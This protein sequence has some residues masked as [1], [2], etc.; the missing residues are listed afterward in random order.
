M[1]SL[2]IIVVTYNSQDTVSECLSSLLL[3]KV[4]YGFELFVIDNASTDNTV[5]IIKEKFTDAILICNKIN[6]G[7]GSALNQGIRSS[8]GDYILALNSDVILEDNFINMLNKKIN[9]LSSDTG[10][11]SP[12]VMCMNNKIDSA[13]LFLSTLRRLYDIGRGYGKQEKFN[14][15]VYIFGACGACAVYKR[16][17]LEDIKIG[18]EYFDEDFF[19]FVEDFDLAWRAKLLKW[20]VEYVPELECF[21]HG[22]ISRK[23]TKLSQYYAF[24][25]RYFLLIKNESMPGLIKI[26]LFSICYD[27]PRLIYLLITNS[28]TIKALR[29]I[30]QMSSAMAGKRKEIF[31]KVH[32]RKINENHPRC[33]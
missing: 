19:L 11:V 5:N 29:E 31:G 20:K 33:P 10:I 12:R 2:S 27:F 18:D 1:L 30:K 14:L 28:Y 21:H 4:D 32:N 7:Y 23:K 25:N 3:Q 8:K 15:P 26:I 24:R 17:T 22:G 16:K 6:R 9:R 13:G